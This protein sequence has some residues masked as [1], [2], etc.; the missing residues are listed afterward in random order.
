MLPDEKLPR[1]PHCDQLLIQVRHGVRLGPLA[2]RIYDAVH[3]AGANGIDCDDLFSLA[4]AGRVAT[5][6]ALKAYVS[7]INE[8]ISEAPVRIKCSNG[9][10]RLVKR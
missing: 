9:S 4:Y 6:R 10:Y 7:R 3:R 2:I 8:K 1:C 5:R